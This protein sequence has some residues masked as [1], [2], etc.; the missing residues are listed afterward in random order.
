M[1]KLFFAL[2]CLLIINTSLIAQ[3]KPSKVALIGFYNLEN[4]YDTLDAPDIADEEFTPLGKKK[5]D[6]LKYQDKINHM[7]SAISQIGTDITSD[8]VA[9]L[10]ISE[11]ENRSV[12]ED[13]IKQPCL[14][15]RDYRIVHFDSPD[16]RGVDVGLIYQPKYFKVIKAEP[17]PAI[18]Y[19]DNNERIYTRDVLYVNGL[20]DGE[21]VHILVN[22]WPSRRGGQAATAKLRNDVAKINRRIMDSLALINPNVKFITMGDLNDDPT[23]VSIKN[24]LRAHGTIDHVKPGNLY[25]PMIP[26]YKAGKGT[27]AFN[28][29]W[30]LFD[31]IIISYGLLNAPAGGFKYYKTEI[32][33]KKFLIQ[34]DG[35]FVGYP[36]RTFDG[37]VYMSGYSDHFPVY[38][39]FSKPV[40]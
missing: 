18:L 15:S 17:I 26:L 21:E 3:D 9:I 14:I 31:Q 11:I 37:D 23:D 1:S 36:L 39:I 24:F 13:L 32:F 40:N 38:I 29:S 5:W 33:N 8:G 30:D 34:N 22:H 12:V 7:S 35:N 28:D 20:L 2:F 10:G 19:N 25:D 16:K 27:L 4:L 6:G